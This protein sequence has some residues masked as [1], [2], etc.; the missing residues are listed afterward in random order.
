MVSVQHCV[1]GLRVRIWR[2]TPLSER[3]HEM[4]AETPFLYTV[5]RMC[6]FTTTFA[7]GLLQRRQFG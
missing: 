1:D 5:F 2:I 7:H 3:H 4:R 6:L